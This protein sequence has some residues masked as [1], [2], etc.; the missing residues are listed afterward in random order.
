MTQFLAPYKYHFH[1]Q[2]RIIHYFIHGDALIIE[3]LD[4]IKN[5]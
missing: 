3:A 2:W 4:R 1:M 5:F